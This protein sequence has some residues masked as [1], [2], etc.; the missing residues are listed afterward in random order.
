MQRLV[1]AF[2][3]CG[4]TSPLAW[5]W[6]ASGHHM[7]A[8]IAY[9]LMNPA[10]QREIMDV[11]RKHPQ[12]DL[13]FRPPAGVTDR[14]SVER[15]QIGIAGCWPDIIRDTDYD[16]PTWHY[17]LGASVVIGNVRP[18]SSPGPLPRGATMATQDLY[19]SQAVALCL[20]TFRDT[21]TA[22]A[23]RAVAL[24]WLLHL[25]ADGHQPCHAGSLYAPA[26]KDGDRGGNS[27]RLADGSNLHATWDKLLGNY[28]SANEVRG[29]VA[30][31]GEIRNTMMAEYRKSG[32]GDWLRPQTWLM[33]SREASK[34]FVYTDEVTGPV[35]AASRGI[36]NKVGP[37]K[38]SPAYYKAAGELAQYRIKQAGFRVGAVLVRSLAAP[39]MDRRKGKRDQSGSSSK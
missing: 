28:P 6:A 10:Q 25:F 35:I 26:F 2:L 22:D 24:C 29:R 15:W 14:G 16:R 9:D 33:E 39:P 4:L 18:P 17:E 34:A 32:E 3:F 7:V 21:S 37:I 5:G 20:D 27:I 30:A 1:W 23:D 36:T 8:V 11:L 13:H 19:L 38:L 12:F 31:L